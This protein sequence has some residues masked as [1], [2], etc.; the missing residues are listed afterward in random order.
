MKR[1]GKIAVCL[2]GGLVLIAGARAADP[3]PPD[4]LLADNPYAPVVIRNV[5]GLNPPTTN[6]P[7]AEALAANPP[8]KITPNGIMD[9]FGQL[10]VLYKVA[11]KP[12]QK[13]AKEESY[14]LSEGQ[15]QD[16]IEV[17]H[18]NQKTGLITF[19]NHGTVQELPLANTPAV[20]TPA[21]GPGGGGPGGGG[22]I[23]PRI[24][25][26]RFG[27]M[28]GGGGVIGGSGSSGR[29]GNQNRGA[30]SGPSMNPDT[31]GASGGFSGG[32]TA[33]TTSQSQSDISAEEQ[34][35]LIAA[36]HLKAQQE[37]HPSAPIFPPTMLDKEAGIT[38]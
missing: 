10:Q 22:G 20:N 33:S 18:I 34:M 1:F 2:A 9:I 25:G 8:L 31:T 37:G 13:D 35:V 19:N 21:P 15:Q 17:I 12:G 11:P 38:P 29:F 27:S 5:F 36:Q 6:D 26:P 4:A 30:G 23:P 7:N 32:G 16:D 28:G 14:I 24:G 3:A